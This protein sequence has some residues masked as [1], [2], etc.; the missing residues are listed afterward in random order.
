MRL[1]EH[2]FASYVQERSS[3]TIAQLIHGENRG[4]LPSHEAR[5]VSK[6]ENEAG[7]V[8]PIGLKHMKK[9][10]VSFVVAIAIGTIALFGEFTINKISTKSVSIKCP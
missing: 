8:I 4:G 6:I 2:G 9:L 5:I 3:T 1:G 7:S 10:M